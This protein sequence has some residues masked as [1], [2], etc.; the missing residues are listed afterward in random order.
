MVSITNI[1]SRLETEDKDSLIDAINEL[2]ELLVSIERGKGSANGYAPLNNMSKVPD[3]N[4]PEASQSA[5]GTVRLSS[6]VNS[7]S[8]TEA[9]TP[10]AVKQVYD[11]VNGKAGTAT[12]T[13]TVAGLMHP[14]DKVKLNGIATGAN[15]YSHPTGDGSL[16]VPATGTTNSGKF[17]KAGA[18]AGSIT[19]GLITK[20]DVGLAN[21]E[22]TSDANKP[23]SN[24]TQTALNGK[25]PIDSPT[26]TGVPQTPTAALGTNSGQIAST[27]FV[28]NAVALKNTITGNAATATTLQTSRTIALSGAAIGT[29]TSF[30]GS[31]N[32]TIPVTSLDPTKFSQAV[33]VASG[34]TGA[35]S[36][37]VGHALIGNGTGAVTTRGI[38]TSPGGSE[39]NSL[40]TTGAV[41][42][43][44]EFPKKIAI[45]PAS[46]VSNLS[47]L[48]YV[49]SMNTD[50]AFT[51]GDAIHSLFTKKLNIIGRNNTDS[52]IIVSDSLN[53]VS[54][55]NN[56]VL[57]STGGNGQL[58]RGIYLAKIVSV[59]TST[60]VI[61]LQL[62]INSIDIAEAWLV[63][64]PNYSAE[65]HSATIGESV[66]TLGRRSINVGDSNVASG[67]NSAT[68]GVGHRTSGFGSLTG[69]VYA[70]MKAGL[71]TSLTTNADLLLIGNGSSA[72][73]S[74]AFRVN[75]GGNVY[76]AAAYNSSGADYAEYFE[77]ADGN[78]NGEER[79]GMVVALEHDKI[80]PA[81][82]G[83]FVLGIVSATPS[84]VGDAYEDQ[85]S[86][87][88]E[89]DA[90][91]RKVIEYHE[92]VVDGVTVPATRFKLNEAYNS[93]ELYIPRSERKEWAAIGMMGKLLVRCDGSVTPNSYAKPSDTEPGT[94]TYSFEPT[95]IRV[96]KIVDGG[97]A[98]VLIK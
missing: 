79:I 78:V 82:D 73:R 56:S 50:G 13:T 80:V 88:Y 62:P 87:M 66:A 27:A 55:N 59:N 44:I 18:T 25:A 57:F 98:Q 1:L 51:V 67:F 47:N 16:H 17:L 95:N 83:S 33:P 3:V 61:E 34:G 45:S 15:F 54:P 38:D 11:I 12:A 71:E 52:V 6:S 30:N 48:H 19:W 28:T 76:G 74:N 43:G 8:T 35:A 63:A 69:G 5:K 90:W 37:A 70:D 68:F 93:E 14:D 29:A 42:E 31:A 72:A 75:S 21:V 7:T 94:L 46:R 84:V 85:W 58:S 60:R 22:N 20:E 53:G 36:L 23:I 39:G 2:N 10:Y 92:E 26:L 77:W 4:L 65:M 32:I 91:G 49:G 81:T 24:A 41:K 89:K 64:A 97:I 86:G 40:I 96:M 9:A